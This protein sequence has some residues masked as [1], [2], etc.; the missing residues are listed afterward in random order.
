MTSPVAGSCT[1]LGSSV[2]IRI[3][4]TMLWFNTAKDLGALRTGD[5]ERIEVPGT[6]FVPGEKPVGRCAGKAIEFEP[7]EGAVTCVA[8]VPEVSPRRAR[9]RRRR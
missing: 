2:P 5:G 3:R 9:M 4:G 6:A 1:D 8:F 7:L